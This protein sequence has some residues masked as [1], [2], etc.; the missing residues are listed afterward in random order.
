MAD[1]GTTARPAAKRTRRTTAKGAAAPTGAPN[2]QHPKTAV[3][4]VHGMGEQRPLETIRSFVEGVYQ[5]DLALA[6]GNTDGR[7]MLRISIVPDSTSGSAELRRLTTLSDGPEKRTDFFEFYWADI[8]DGTPVEMVTGWI[9]GLLLR[10]PWR[11]PV[12]GRVFSAWL[13]L[14]LLALVTLL[15]AAITAHP[16]VAQYV[17]G[18]SAALTWLAEHRLAIAKGLY[19]VGCLVLA[20]RVSTALTARPR[21]VEPQVKVNPLRRWLERAFYRITVDGSWVDGISLTIPALLMVAGLALALLQR[22]N[23][24]DA[25]L[26]AGGFTALLAWIMNALVA[27]YLGDVVRYVRATPSTVGKREEVRKRGLGLLEAIHAKRLKEGDDWTDFAKAAKDDPPYYDRIVLVG[28]S[29]GSIIAYDLLQLFWE[30][31]GPTHHQHWAVGAT[32]MQRAL[33]RVD[34]YVRK[35]WLRERPLRPR[36]ETAFHKRQQQLGV[37]LGAETPHWRITDFITLGSPLAHA[38]FLMTD[39]DAELLQAFRE[40]RF[41]ASPPRPDLLTQSMLYQVEPPDGPLYPHFAAQFAAA[42]WT[43]IC[44][45]S[46]VPILGDLVSGRLRGTFGP[47]IDEFN[48]PIKRPGLIWPLTR[49]FTHTEY[50]TWDERY[51]LGNVPLHLKLLRQA[52]RLGQ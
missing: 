4:L 15:S 32:P 3:V 50:W 31:H 41:A 47:G 33:K 42:R 24:I 30:R 17:P 6:S 38:A 18:L 2:G 35:V 26:W 22:T 19:V 12:A 9:R 48:V 23:V 1:T 5:H 20:W 36:E 8:M 43:N 46:P 39:G 27:P 44:D 52:L 16:T 40:R 37:Q 7:N 34:L 13:I 45:E 14:W 28:H 49:V 11:V 51:R 10:A 25:H 21:V 29:L